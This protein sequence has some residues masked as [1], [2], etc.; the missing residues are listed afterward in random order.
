MKKY[1]IVSTYPEYGSKNIGDQLI[2]SALI[3]VIKFT[4]GANVEIDI[5][6][7]EDSWENIKERVFNA[8]AVVFA[9]LAI[10]PNMSVKEYPFLKNLLKENIPLAVVS[11]GTSIPVSCVKKSVLN[12]VS[13]E[14]KEQLLSLDRNAIFFTTRGYLTQFFCES[15]GLSNVVFS[16][17]VAFFNQRYKDVSFVEGKKINK[18]VI[19]D[20]HHSKLY[21]RSFNAL[22]L[23]LR[24]KYNDAEIVVALH[25]NDA[26]IKEYV[27]RSGLKY[28]EVFKDKDKGLSIYDSADLHVGYRVHAHVSSLKRG[29]Y[30]YL[31]EQD[32]RGC[33]YGLTINRKISVPSYC[34][35]RGL[36][37]KFMGKF[38]F[39]RYAVGVS[40]VD[41]IISLVSQDEVLGFHKFLGLE[42]QLATFSDDIINSIKKLP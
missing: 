14:T 1:I 2:T 16:G 28:I 31:L 40:P 5:V 19:S 21:L 23:A 33:D 24:A 11:A 36:L 7:R 12:Y 39:N 17:D 4:K 37:E 26:A 18:I 6:W 15:I 22:V 8:D 10:R 3:D 20:P 35:P 25:G 27:N 32:G 38:G 13:N 30:S 9:C 42:K 29:V 34:Q 41:Q